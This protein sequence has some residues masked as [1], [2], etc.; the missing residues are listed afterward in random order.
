VHTS[1]IA[2]ASFAAVQTGAPQ[3]QAGFKLVPVPARIQVTGYGEVK[4][5][6]DIA[7]ITYIVRG[8]GATSDDAVRAMTGSAARIDSA[9]AAIDRA[10]EPRTSEVKVE[11]VRSDDCKEQ[12]YGRPQL[13]TGACA[14]SG[15]VATQTVT[16][17]T[18]AVEDAGTMVGLVG[19]AGGLNPRIENFTI[20]DSRPQ[21]QQAIAAALADAASKAAAMAAASRVGLGPILQIDSERRNDAQQIVVSGSRINSLPVAAPPPPPPV[22]VKLTPELL[23][24]DSYVTVMYEIEQ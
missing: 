6:P 13:S 9:L 22:P 2:L 18:T 3:P 20:R 16:L 24:T 5:M 12:Q 11:Q 8:E 15:Y 17:R 21:Q 23:S 1:L 10:A 14:I 7:T 19:R 4:Y